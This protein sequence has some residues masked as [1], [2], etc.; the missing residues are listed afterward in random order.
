MIKVNVD[1]KNYR[2]EFLG[3]SLSVAEVIQFKGQ[4]EWAAS[5]VMGL[6][7]KADTTVT[8]AATPDRKPSETGKNA[9]PHQPQRGGNII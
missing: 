6:P 4:L 5:A 2:V 9:T 8:T 1:S 7:V 3:L